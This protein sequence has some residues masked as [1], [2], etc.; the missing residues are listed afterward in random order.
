M[1]DLE[2]YDSKGKI[3]GEFSS[4]KKGKT[5]SSFSESLFLCFK[6]TSKMLTIKTANRR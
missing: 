4:V 1:C 6:I 5:F 3:D 2:N